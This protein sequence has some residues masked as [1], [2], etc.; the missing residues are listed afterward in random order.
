M[1]AVFMDDIELEMSLACVESEIERLT[2]V[3]TEYRQRHVTPDD[4]EKSLLSLIEALTTVRD[5]MK[6]Q[7][8]A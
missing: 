8:E 7:L 1:P 5:N 2:T 4:Q 3:V 6:T